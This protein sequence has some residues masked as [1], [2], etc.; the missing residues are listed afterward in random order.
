MANQVADKLKVLKSFV[1]TKGLIRERYCLIKDKVLYANNGIAQVEMPIEL[2]FNSYFNYFQ[3][4][5]VLSTVKSESVIVAKD[6]SLTVQADD[7][8]YNIGTEPLDSVT[9]INFN[10]STEFV[11]CDSPRMFKKLML[12]AKDY[13]QP[14]KNENALNYAVEFLY[15]YNNVISF[16]DRKNLFQGILDFAMPNMAIDLNSILSFNAILN[17]KMEITG[18]NL[19][20]N[21]LGIKFNNDVKI[22]IPILLTDQAQLW[23]EKISKV[24]DDIMK[25]N[26]LSLNLTDNVIKQFDNVIKLSKGKIIFFNNSFCESF[27]TKIDYPSLSDKPFSFRASY[28]N[29]K[30]ILSITNNIGI[31]EKNRLI[32]LTNEIR[33]VINGMGED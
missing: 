27:F 20:G 17:N 28:S 21:I 1:K 18:F 29:L 11:E 9:W 14:I 6:D 25:E 26:I 10:N 15:I 16:T 4:F 24:A 3:L 8:I 22:Y 30:N 19:N 5:T 7:N 33:A 2:P 12:L 31:S 32:C 13:V 23:Y